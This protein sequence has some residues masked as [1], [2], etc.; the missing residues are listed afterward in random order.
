MTENTPS[1]EQSGTA[2]AAESTH[3]I[4]QRGLWFEEFEIGAVYKHAPGRTITEADN[5][6]FTAV[7]M[8]TQACL[9]YTSP[10]PRD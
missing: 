10:S 3:V 5:T 7:T 1:P 6:W 4:Q 2:D 8:N 9:L